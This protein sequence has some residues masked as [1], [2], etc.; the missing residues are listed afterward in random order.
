M[1]SVQCLKRH[2]LS[3][4][5]VEK[6]EREGGSRHQQAKQTQQRSAFN[7]SQSFQFIHFAIYIKRDSYLIYHLILLFYTY[8]A[9]YNERE[10][11]SCT[12]YTSSGFSGPALSTIVCSFNNQEDDPSLGF[13]YISHL[14]RKI[15]RKDLKNTAKNELFSKFNNL[16]L[17]KLQVSMFLIIQITNF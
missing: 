14:K 2:L 1:P 3:F 8:T 15:R 11:I 13:V 4:K 9:I 17:S 6:G 7:D 5:H 10:D 16:N 12:L